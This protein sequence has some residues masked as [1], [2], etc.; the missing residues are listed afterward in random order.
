[1]AF[2]NSFGKLSN[3]NSS[4]LYL[5]FGTPHIIN[6]ISCMNFLVS[7]LFSPFYKDIGLSKY[8]N[9]PIIKTYINI[10]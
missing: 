4:I 6:K 10:K 9:N 8:S 1:M 5:A 7:R 2:K 3:D